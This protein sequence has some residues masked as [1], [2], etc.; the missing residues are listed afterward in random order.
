LFILSRLELHINNIKLY[1]DAGL[2]CTPTSIV[3]QI[4]TNKYLD[5]GKGKEKD[6]EVGK[7]AEKG[8]EWGK[9]VGKV[10]GPHVVVSRNLLPM[11]SHH[12]SILDLR[13]ACFHSTRF[14]DESR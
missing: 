10:I 8:V 2:I 12:P 1:Q 11:S 5:K 14:L 6:T 9:M 3:R 13:H 7:A 4:D